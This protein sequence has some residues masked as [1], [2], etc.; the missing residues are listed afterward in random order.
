MQRYGR[1]TEISKVE[2]F[3]RPVKS[4]CRA[5]QLVNARDFAYF[6]PAMRLLGKIAYW[7]AALALLA[8]ILVSLDYSLVQAILIS[9]IFCPCAVALEYLMPKARKPMDKVYLSLA[10]LVAV[11]VLILILHY[12]VWSRMNPLGYSDMKNV[13]PMLINPAFLG[14]ILTTLSIGD[15]IWSKWLDRRFKAEDRTIT[16]FSDRKSVTLRLSDIA[17]VESNDT[18]VRIVTTAGDAYRNKTGITQWENL[19]GDGF[20]RIHRSVLVN[21]AASV[22][23]SPDTVSVAGKELPVS[24]KYKDGVKAILAAGQVQIPEPPASNKNL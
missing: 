16:F 12:S 22:L 4:H 10:A 9:L 5:F 7:L 14:L 1:C 13:A 3:S 15:Y 6:C 24:R 20:L 21:V 23:A 11:V 2:T 17:Y 8:A 19:L 18:E